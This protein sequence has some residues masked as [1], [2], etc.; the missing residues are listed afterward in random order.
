MI[1]WHYRVVSPLMTLCRICFWCLVLLALFYLGQLGHALFMAATT[2][3]AV[4]KIS[5]ST[6][7]PSPLCPGLDWGQHSRFL[8]SLPGAYLSYPLEVGPSAVNPL[9]LGNPQFIILM[10]LH[11]FGW[12]YVFVRLVQLLRSQKR[13]T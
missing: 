9:V 5:T 2:D 1:R 12:S 4:C 8:L 7:L 6:L 3:P 11:A 13:R 10:L